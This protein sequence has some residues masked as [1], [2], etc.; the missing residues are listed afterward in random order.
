MRATTQSLK[1]DLAAAIAFFKTDA[2]AKTLP[3]IRSDFPRDACETTSTLLAA[4]LADKYPQ[5]EV[6]LVH[7]RSARSADHLWVEV[8]DHVVDV[9]AH[10]FPAFKSPLVCPTPSPLAQEYSD[11]DR[12]T[13]TVALRARERFFQISTTQRDVLIARLRGR[14][15]SVA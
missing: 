6:V 13:V 9:T 3:F 7:G 4:A 11:I 2:E 14:L 12:Q 1:A 5:S 10:Q 8:D 15:E